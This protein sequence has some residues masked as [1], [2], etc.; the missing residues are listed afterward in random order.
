MLW[1]PATIVHGAQL[2]PGERKELLAA[3]GADIVWN[4]EPIDGMLPEDREAL[5]AVHEQRV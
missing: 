1:S 2:S 5:E 4:G 3:L